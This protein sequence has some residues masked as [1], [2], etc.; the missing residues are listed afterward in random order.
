MLKNGT[1][2]EKQMKQS[3]MTNDEASR[4]LRFLIANQHDVTDMITITNDGTLMTLKP[5]DREERDVYRLTII[6][7]YFQGYVTGAG[8]YQVIIHV[9]DVNDNP[10]VFNLHTYSGSIAEK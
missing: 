9:E 2:L 10:P 5:L 3:P 8:I 6:A 1:R 7:E 4:G